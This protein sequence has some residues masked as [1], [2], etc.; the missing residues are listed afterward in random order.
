MSEIK[1]VGPYGENLGR[2]KNLKEEPLV[3]PIEV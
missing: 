2:M 3:P 1:S